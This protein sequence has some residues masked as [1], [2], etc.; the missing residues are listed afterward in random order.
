MHRS[1]RRSLLALCTLGCAFASFAAAAQDSPESLDESLQR[2]G[3]TVEH[4]VVRERSLVE[5]VY[6]TPEDLDTPHHK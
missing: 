5:G 1:F 2:V 4:H 3:P 6:A